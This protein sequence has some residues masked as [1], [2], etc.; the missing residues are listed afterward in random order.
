MEMKWFS[1]FLGVVAIITNLS[2]VFQG[3]KIYFLKK[4]TFFAVKF[5]TL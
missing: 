4:N 2:T 1:I 3:A 5:M